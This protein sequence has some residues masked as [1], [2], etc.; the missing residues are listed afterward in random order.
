MNIYEILNTKMVNSK[1][2]QHLNDNNHSFGPTEKVMNVLHP[3]RK[4]TMMDTLEK[5]H[6]Y[7]ATKLGTQINDKNTMLHN[8]LFNT[9]IYDTTRLEGIPNA[10]YSPTTSP[11][12]SQSYHWPFIQPH[13]CSPWRPSNCK[14]VITTLH[15]T[16]LC[17]I[18]I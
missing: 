9:L 14:F 5:Y 1:F 8:M 11:R 17:G 2:A 13:R 16:K 18:Y 12:Q 15:I 6:I 7:K 3:I 4:G 10:L